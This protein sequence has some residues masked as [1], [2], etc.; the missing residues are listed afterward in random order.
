M[1]RTAITL[2][3]K[4]RWFPDEASYWAETFYTDIA[5]APLMPDED[6]SFGV[7]LVLDFRTWW[8]HVQTKNSV[9]L[10]H[11]VKVQKI[12]ITHENLLLITR[13]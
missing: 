11:S 6:K 4:M 12:N 8:R 10:L 2:K 9:N 5:L 1:S 13:E 7:S 3:L